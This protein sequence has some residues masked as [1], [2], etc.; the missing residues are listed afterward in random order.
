MTIHCL[1]FRLYVEVTFLISYIVFI[2][3]TTESQENKLQDLS[4]CL[5]CGNIWQLCREQSERGNAEG[6]VETG[7]WKFN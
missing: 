3:E 6:C 5:S 1:W 4:Y 2:I 7:D